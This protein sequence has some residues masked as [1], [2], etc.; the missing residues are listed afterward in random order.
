MLILASQ[1][2]RRKQLLTLAGWQFETRPADVD[3]QPGAPETPAVYVQRLARAKALEVARQTPL[4]WL[5]VA[6]DTTVAD[7]AAILGKPVDEAEA[8]AMLRRLRGRVHSVYTGLAVF[9]PVDQA[10]LLDLCVTEVKMR[11]YSEAELRA[12]IAS[13]DPL[14]K[15]GAY[16]IQH[17][18]FNPVESLVGCYANVVGLP[19]CHLNRLLEQFGL[20]TPINAP[21]VC[22]GHHHNSCAFSEKI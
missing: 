5:V 8:A 9:R 21:V 6:A 17:S 16:A 7:G 3:E 2:P 12:Y 22:R 15:A 18:G 1:S 14:D 19:V 11:L 4:D 20:A 13:G 10:L